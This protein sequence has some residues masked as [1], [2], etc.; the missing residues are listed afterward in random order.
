M[1]NLCN[2]QLVEGGIHQF[3]FTTASRKAVDQ[4]IDH[5]ETILPTV[6]AS[7]EIRVLLDIRSAGFPPIA[8]FA[9]RMRN[10]NY[11]LPYRVYTRTVILYQSSMIL[12][13]LETAIFLLMKPSH[14]TVQFVHNNRTDAVNW[15]LGQ[16]MLRPV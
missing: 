6:T 12:S 11:R 4:Y 8:Y 3:T 1:S 2:Y 7:A 5:L 16:P 14:D 10:L 13:L 15:L 9:T